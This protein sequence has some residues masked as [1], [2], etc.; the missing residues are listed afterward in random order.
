MVLPGGATPWSSLS[1]E[2]LKND[3]VPIPGALDKVMDLQGVLF[4]WKDE[5]R[6][7]MGRQMGFVAQQAEHIIPEVVSLRGDQ[8]AM[9]YAPITALLVEAIKEQQQIIDQKEV[10]MDELKAR[11]DRLERLILS[12]K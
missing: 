12:Y 5:E 10:E 9:Q 7:D 3:I 6:Q 2:R 4:S 1:D 8:Y 11:I